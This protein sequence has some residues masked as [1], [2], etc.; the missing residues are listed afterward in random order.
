M[1]SERTLASAAAAAVHRV[2]RRGL[3][4]DHLPPAGTA[5]GWL[6]IGRHMGN[7]IASSRRW[8]RRAQP[9]VATQ[10]SRGRAAA[11]AKGGAVSRATSP[12]P[13]HATPPVAAEALE[14]RL[15]MAG[16]VVI[17]ELMYHA[18]SQD[19]RDEWLELHNRGPTAVSLAGWR[20]DKGIDF[21]FAAGTSI[22]AGQFLVVAHDLAR[23]Q[24][25][26][27]GVGNVV[28]GWTRTLANNGETLELVDAGGASQD[29][30]DYASEGDWAFRRRG[31]LSFNHRGW[32][33]TTPAD[34]GGSSMELVNPNLGN[35]SGQNWRPS[36]TGGTPGRANRGAS[37][38]AAPLV[39]DMRQVP[40]VP[41]S[42]QFVTVT[43]RMVDEQPQAAGVTAAVHWRVDGAAGFTVTP[44]ADDGAHGDGAA[45]DGVFG[46]TLPPQAN[47]TVVE[48]YLRA[49]DAAA[50]SRTWP[51]PTDDA[52]GQQANLL[53]QVDDSAAYT[54]GQVYLK[55]IMT[56]AER[57]ELAQIG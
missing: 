1:R 33:W 40:L 36:A 11:R 25:Q 46:A 6:C 50:H 15:V 35:N 32:D 45:G 22:G 44:M 9:G 51:G 48:Y 2:R 4:V 28:G 12:A 21:T 42:S 56:A 18:S 17:N 57:A 26:H 38:D 24:S 3:G 8:D 47:N 55:L 14:R 37:A 41:R 23:F 13:S 34:G 10:Q 31:P 27:A 49:T 29:K 30:L 5:A 39:T 20:F 19:V 16:N 43:A 7:Q 52:G 54:G 53:Y